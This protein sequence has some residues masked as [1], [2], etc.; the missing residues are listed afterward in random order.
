MKP[1]ARVTPKGVDEL[2]IELERSSI[3]GYEGISLICSQMEFG[4]SNVSSF[5]K[6]A[7]VRC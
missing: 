7:G 6:I 2:I 1:L 3:F 5:L 4:K